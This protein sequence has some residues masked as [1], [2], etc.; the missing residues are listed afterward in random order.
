[1]V[2][3]PEPLFA[4][5][6]AADPPRP[7]L[8]LGPGGRR[9]DQALAARA[10]RPATG[11]RC[12]AAATRAS[13]SGSPSTCATASSRSA[14]TCWPAARSAA[15]VVLEAVGRLVPGVMGNEAS[16]GEESFADGL[17]EYPQYTRPAEFRGWEVPEVLRSG[18]H[19]RIARWRRAAGARPHA[20]SGA[21]TS[22][23][24]GAAS[25]DDGGCAVLAELGRT[26]LSSDVPIS[27]PVP[28]V[29]A[30]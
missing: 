26:A 10:G 7:L 16:A 28:G 8:L 29:A 11:S 23:R 1:M 6:E 18:D 9:F 4:A 20:S 5:V 15:L 3:R 25:A 24:P 21:P 13:T 14:T 12:C 2:L 17:L 27:R 19:G 30:P 22:S